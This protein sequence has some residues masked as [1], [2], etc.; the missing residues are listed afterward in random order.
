MLETNA[1]DRVISGILSQKQR[2]DLWRPI[3]YFSK[4]I[5]SAEYNYP[6]YNKELLAIIQAFKEYRA[7][8]KELANPTQVYSDHK[9]LEYFIT[10]KNLSARQAY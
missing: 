6:I 2:N 1:S 9:A 8:L 4:T 5:N 3:A 10:T 7:K